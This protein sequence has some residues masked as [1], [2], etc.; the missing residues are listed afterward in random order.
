MSALHTT[1]ENY[2]PSSRLSVGSADSW[3]MQRW[4]ERLPMYLSEEPKR[5]KIV[6]ALTS[7]LEHFATEGLQR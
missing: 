2:I 5:Q 4:C 6:K 7:A 3:E 1:R